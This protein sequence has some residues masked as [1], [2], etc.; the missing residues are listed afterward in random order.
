MIL[1]LNGIQFAVNFDSPEDII[2][3]TK[4]ISAEIDNGIAVL[5][6]FLKSPLFLRISDVGAIIAAIGIGFWV[7]KWIKDVAKS[8]EFF[9]SDKMP[10]IAFG[11]LLAV[12]LGA[13]TERGKLLSDVLIGFDALSNNLSNIVLVAARPETEKDPIA[14]VQVRQAVVDRA[15]QDAI[16]CQEFPFY[17][18]ERTSC[19]G[20]AIERLQTS[21]DNYKS[22]E[23]AK[24]LEDKWVRFLAGLT[25]D[26]IGQYGQAKADRDIQAA[27]EFL[28]SGLNKALIGITFAI[29]CGLVI[30]A[31]NCQAIDICYF[32]DC[33]SA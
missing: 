2:Q 26:S 20:E 5:W 16:A 8:D 32:P 19:I 33:T 24:S 25:N 4:D 3:N 30:I 23:W 6:D 7:I 28:E 15:N 31:E 27:R 13:P 10:Q 11:L 12:L 17:S 18:P 22:E 9:V 29:S 14:S 1:H 21:L